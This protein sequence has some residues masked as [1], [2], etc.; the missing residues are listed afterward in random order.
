MT[1]CG[2]AAS[3]PSADLLTTHSHYGSA[4]T[5]PSLE[6]YP[7]R[8][9][10]VHYRFKS[11]KLGGHISGKDELWRFS[12]QQSEMFIFVDEQHDFIDVNIASPGKG[13]TWYVTVVNLLVWLV[14]ICKVAYQKS[15]RSV[16]ICI[17]CCQKNEWH[18]FLFGHVVLS[19]KHCTF[20][21]FV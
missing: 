3:T 16:H 5:R 20:S 18:L 19:F 2:P 10:L 11:C 8:S 12:L 7:G 14:F 1:D 4:N 9:A 21:S 13:C 17:G 15:W 6:G